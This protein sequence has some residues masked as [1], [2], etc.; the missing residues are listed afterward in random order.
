MGDSFR[1]CLSCDEITRWHKYWRYG[2]H[3][4]C[5]K[6]GHPSLWA[7]QGEPTPGRIAERR[8]ELRYMM[9]GKMPSY[10]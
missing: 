8:A 2:G 9:G 10:V 5:K 6:C 3:S 4:V 7:V 1:F